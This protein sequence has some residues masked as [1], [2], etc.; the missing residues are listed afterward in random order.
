MR[1]GG[2]RNQVGQCEIW[3]ACDKMK[4]CPY[5]LARTLSGAFPF[6]RGTLYDGREYE[7]AENVSD[8]RRERSSEGET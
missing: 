8:A 4:G 1:A 5:D 3:R 2:L 6:Y 7:A